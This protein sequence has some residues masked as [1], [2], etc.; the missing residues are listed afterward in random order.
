MINKI[1]NNKLLSIIVLVLSITVLTT[2]GRFVYDEIKKNFFLTQDF[3]FNSDKLKEVQANYT[4]NNYN[5]VDDYD[6]VINVD[7]IKN[8]LVKS[9]HDIAYNISYSCTSNANCGT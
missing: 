5:G 1:K 8:N 3:Y 7:S 2:A 9:S 4:I 6:I